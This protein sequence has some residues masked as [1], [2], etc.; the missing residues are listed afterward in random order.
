V[1]SLRDDGDRI[2]PEF[3][4]GWAEGGTWDLGEV[5]TRDYGYSVNIAS[6]PDG[7]FQVTLASV[8]FLGDFFIDKSVLTIDYNAVPE[9]A[10]MLL[11]GLGLLGVAGIRRFRK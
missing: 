11:L 6:L 7:V 4:F 9:P 2:L 3:A 1:L 10:T 5:D 8:S